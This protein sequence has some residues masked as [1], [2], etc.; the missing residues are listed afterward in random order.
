[1][2]LKDRP[3]TPGG[4]PIPH[5]VVEKVD[6]NMPSHGEVPGTA[7]YQQR[8]ADAV[9]D[10]VMKMPEDGGS[11]SPSI[12]TRSSRSGS[13]DTPVPETLLSRVDSL[14]SE[15]ES[16]VRAHRRSPSDAL[17]DSTERI[18][19]L[20]GKLALPHCTKYPERLTNSDPPTSSQTSATHR[21]HGRRRSTL[22]GHDAAANRANPDDFDDFAE[23]QEM[24]EDD[25]GDFDDG[26]QG[27]G[28]AVT[29][30]A[31]EQGSIQP[32][33]P[34]TP[35]PVVSSFTHPTVSCILTI[36][37]YSHLWI[38][39]PPNQST[40]SLPLSTLTSTHSFRAPKPFPHYHRSTRFPTLPPS[41]T[42]TAPS[43]FGRNSLHL[44]HCNHRTGSSPE[45][46]VSSSSPSA[47]LST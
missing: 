42:P 41:S 37:L 11:R 6:P 34:P 23:E 16:G 38:S 18:P 10:L 14:P 32:Q 44:L 15:A 26:F 33:Q 30:E 17:P 28:E 2:G 4:S 43:L 27:P 25:F 3:S 45:S 5:T 40:T 47:S 22:K 8:K 20:Q 36:S 13:D 12:N 9:P 39:T 19:K 21:S 31:V 24:G 29:E 35:P 1:M 7:A 46:A